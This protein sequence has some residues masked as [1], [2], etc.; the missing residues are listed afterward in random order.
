MAPTRVA[1]DLYV[2]IDGQILEIKRQLRQR[3]GYPF[4]P[5]KL[6]EHLQAAIE[7]NF[8]DHNGKPLGELGSRASGPAVTPLTLDVDYTKT[9]EQMVEAGKYDW[10]NSDIG[11]KNF[12]VKRRESGKV[13]VHLFHFNRAV[14]S[15]DAIK[16]LGRMGFRPAELPE[17][18]A[19]GAQHPEEQRKY[20][21]IA[22]GS[23]WRSPDGDR[24]VPYLGGSGSGR[25]LGLDWFGGEWSGDYR[26]AA[27]RK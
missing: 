8:V 2:D 13:E 11:S 27:V 9:V 21:I 6:V 25:G 18:L 14:S 5:M 24:S 20:P 26:F 23:V 10:K 3:E 1:G 7:G 16:E 22:L 12:P 19:L 17:L 4:D 15:D